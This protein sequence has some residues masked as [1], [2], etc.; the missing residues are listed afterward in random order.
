MLPGPTLIKKCSACCKPI[1]EDTINSGNTF[2][3]TH[4]TD[5]K[6]EAPMLPDQPWLVM[7]P[8][9][10]APLWLDEL[11]E[12]GEI[13]YWGAEKKQFGDAR[14]FEQPALN[15]YLALLVNGVENPEKARYIRLCAWWAG[16]DL[17]RG[18]NEKVPMSSPEKANLTAYVG[19]LD[20][21]D[22]EELVMK[23]EGLRELGR[24]DE[25][26]TLLGKPVAQSMQQA[27]EIITKL[28]QEGD[29]YVR[30]MNLTT[31][32]H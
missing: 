32:V 18:N 29:R 19:M 31:V 3:A 28:V 11:E 20:E 12:L 4:W 14:E 8:H 24:F 5:G 30:Q 23:A 6:L 16:N 21:S 17:R 1:K 27:V 9:C 13:K 26:L 15:D 10:H 2:G 25:A 7:C 22:V